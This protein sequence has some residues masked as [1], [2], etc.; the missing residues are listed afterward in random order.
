MGLIMSR[1]EKPLKTGVLCVK[2]RQGN[3]SGVVVSALNIPPGPLHLTCIIGSYSDCRGTEI[4]P[5]MCEY[6]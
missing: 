6:A 2:E 4:V 3:N 1:I 5:C